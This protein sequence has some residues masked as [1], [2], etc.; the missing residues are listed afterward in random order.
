[1]HCILY[2]L[3]PS[4]T[5][6]WLGEMKSWNNV[7]IYLPTPIHHTNTKALYFIISRFFDA[8]I[9]HLQKFK[10]SF[11]LDRNIIPTRK[12]LNRLWIHCQQDLVQLMYTHIVVMQME[13]IV[14]LIT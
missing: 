3:P 7:F 10:N 1:M 12:T 14:K 8:M 6:I 13:D 5:S 11:I 2:K 4:Y 9:N